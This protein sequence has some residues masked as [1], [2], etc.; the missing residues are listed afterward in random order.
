LGTQ[1]RLNFKLPRILRQTFDADFTLNRIASIQFEE[2]IMKAKIFV[3]L[4]AVMLVGT[5]FAGDSGN[6]CKLQGTWFWEL[7]YPLPDNPDFVLKFWAT[8]IGT[9]DNEGSEIVEWINYPLPL[10][11]SSPTARGVWAKSGP[12]NYN[13]TMIGFVSQDETGTI[14]QVLLHNGTKT[15]TGCNTMTATSVIQYLDPDTLEPISPPS[16]EGR[17]GVARRVLLQKP[18]Q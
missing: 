3:V 8:Y 17:G 14:L 5:A 7:P 10:G 18:S 15:L 4:F 6:G 9:G 1:E 12:N 2:E 16:D 13:F 11:L